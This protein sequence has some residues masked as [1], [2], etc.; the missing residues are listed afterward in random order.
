MAKA[1]NAARLNLIHLAHGGYSLW[2]E[3]YSQHLAQ[4]T[5]GL[6]RFPTF[7]ADPVTPMQPEV[8]Y[9]MMRTLCTVM[10]ETEPDESL[11]PE[12]TPT[13]YN[14]EWYGMKKPSGKK[15]LLMWLKGH[16][17]DGPHNEAVVNVTLPESYQKA[18]I[19][20][21]LN[22][23]T[24]DAIIDQGTIRNLHIK[25]WPVILEFC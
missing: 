4:W 5:T 22:G 7:G 18:T 25:D 9:Y 15:L 23:T 24:Q 17:T 11:T 20:D 3:S 12:Y 14:L 10:D 6:L 21:S 19:I 16:P 1:K 2:N 13:P 8:I